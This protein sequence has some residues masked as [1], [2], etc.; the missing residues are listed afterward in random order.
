MSTTICKHLLLHDCEGNLGGIFRLRS[1]VSVQRKGGM[2]PRLRTEYFPV[3]PDSRIAI[4]YDFHFTI[5]TDNNERL[6]RAFSRVARPFTYRYPGKGSG[7][8][9]RVNSFVHCQ[10]FGHSKLVVNEVS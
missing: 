4:M 5:G 7:G 6:Y 3:L 10:H 1:T 9:S 8:L 2:T